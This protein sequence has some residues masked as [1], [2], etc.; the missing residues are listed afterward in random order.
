MVETLI[1]A[2]LHHGIRPAGPAACHRADRIHQHCAA[3]EGLPEEDEAALEGLHIVH[4][5][6]SGLVRAFGAHAPAED[7]RTSGMVLRRDRP[8]VCDNT[9]AM[10][11]VVPCAEDS[12]RLIRRTSVAG[13]EA[14]S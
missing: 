5:V 1:Q 6:Q 14:I 7:P 13:I 2:P 9:E 11:R 3:W 8:V 4:S 10:H 12:G